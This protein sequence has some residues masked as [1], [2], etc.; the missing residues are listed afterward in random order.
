MRDSLKRSAEHTPASGFERYKKGSVVLCNACSKPIFK[1][2]IT[3]SFGDKCGAMARAFKPLSVADMTALGER[4]DIDAGVRAFI[5]GLSSDA[6]KEH[7]SKLREV[8]TGEP[9]LC[10][11]C[12]DCFV[13]ITSIEK[14]EALDRSYTVELVTIPPDGAIVPVRG[15]QVGYGPGKEW[16]H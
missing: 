3:I 9:M 16:I 11:A 14:N 13:Q 15:K 4:E 12:D 8:R 1:L 5:R 10:P 6:M 2:D 7:V